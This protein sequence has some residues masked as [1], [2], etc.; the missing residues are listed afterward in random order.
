MRGSRVWGHRWVAAAVLFAVVLSLGPVPS[1]EADA[2]CGAR[3][4]IVADTVKDNETTLVWQRQVETAG[5]AS[6]G[7]GS[8]GCYAWLD[9]KVYCQGL[10]LADANDWRLP[11]VYELQTIVD[12]SRFGPAIDM[13]AFPGTPSTVFWS[14]TSFADGS[15]DAAPVDFLYGS[16]FYRPMSGMF[17][18]RCVR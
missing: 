5:G 4:T 9:A 1:A 13:T 18:V 14:S 12:E 7:D 17:R 6:C 2:P 10:T 11:T 16:V 8:R 15:S 3:Y